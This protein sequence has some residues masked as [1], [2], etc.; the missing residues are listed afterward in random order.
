MNKKVIVII[1]VLAAVIVL[2]GASVAA[3]FAF[4][5]TKIFSN[6]T[7]TSVTPTASAKQDSTTPTESSDSNGST[8]TGSN[9]AACQ[10]LTPAIAEKVLGVTLKQDTDNNQ[11]T[12]TYSYLNETTGDMKIMTMVISNLGKAQAKNSF[13]MA[14]TSVYQSQTEDISGIDADGAYYAPNLMQLSLLK[15]N[16]WIIISVVTDT[17]DEGKALSIETAKEIVKKL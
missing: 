13:D 1:A 3:F 11:N 7:N 6:L 12:C 2:C 9:G 5:G 14:R 8:G 17:K 10:I 4:G 15:G 16:N